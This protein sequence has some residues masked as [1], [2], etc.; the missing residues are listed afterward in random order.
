MS[1]LEQLIAQHQARIRLH[2]RAKRI[3]MAILDRSALLYL[4]IHR[5]QQSFWAGHLRSM[6]FWT[7][8]LKFYPS[9]WEERHNRFAQKWT[10][11]FKR[12]VTCYEYSS[13]TPEREL[14][15]FMRRPP[16]EIY[17][18]L[19][20]AS[21]MERIL[22]SKTDALAP[23]EWPWLIFHQA[24]GAGRGYYPHEHARA[25]TVAQTGDWT[26]RILGISAPDRIA[27]MLG[28]CLA[29]YQDAQARTRRLAEEFDP[30][31]FRY[32]CDEIRR[33]IEGHDAWLDKR[34]LEPAA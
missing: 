9:L 32:A 18:R 11:E 27:A 19:P 28:I 15:A 13:R 7:D 17:L 29:D 24:D 2:P 8:V 3:A 25:F 4:V 21:D 34:A 20:S 12:I 5:Q 23:H 33:R 14:P 30:Y 10:P 26:R 31:T 6:I 22:N 1:L 16:G